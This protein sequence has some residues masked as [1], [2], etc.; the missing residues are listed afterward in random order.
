MIVLASIADGL[1]IQCSVGISYMYQHSQYSSLQ[2]SRNLCEHPFAL[3]GKNDPKPSVIVENEE[4][5]ED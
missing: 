2:I 3:S 1:L 5:L 4:S